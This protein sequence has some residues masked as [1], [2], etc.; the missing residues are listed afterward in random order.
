MAIS[1]N[2]NVAS[3][4]AQR[5]LVGTERK[6]N[7]A[8][9]RLSSGFRINSA[10]DDAAGLAIT[11][12]MTSQVR[13]LTQAARN[14]N[15]GISLAQTAEGA[16]NETTTLLQRMRELAIQSANDSNSDTDRQSIQDEVVNLQAEIA[17]IAD[18]TSFNNKKL[19]DGSFGNASFHIGAEA[20]Q[21]INVTTGDARANRLGSYRTRLK[22]EANVGATT[23]AATAATQWGGAD[24]VVNGSK[25]SAT[26]TIAVGATAK[27][28]ADAINAKTVD[29]G[30]TA[31]AETKVELTG[32]ADGSYKF[33]L[34]TGSSQTATVSA[35]VTSGDLNDLVDAINDHS[36]ATGVT[37]TLN[38]A[39]DG[40]VMKD[41]DGD[42]ITVQRTDTV[43]DAW[44]AT[45]SATGDTSTVATLSSAAATD[46]ASFRGQV[47]IESEKAFSVAGGASADATSTSSTLS[48]IAT[49]DLKTQT[50]SNDA[51]SVIDKAIAKV[52]SIR[53]KLGAVQNRFESTI[54]NLTNVSENISASRSRILDA[55]FAA[56][57]AELSKAQI[58][59]Q[60]GLSMLSQANQLPQSALSML[61]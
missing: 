37:A 36:A 39:E 17:R 32:I 58:I 45:M 46:T 9:Q 31:S 11:D 15:D 43:A 50:G 51:I 52:D 13:G 25:G 53:S 41:A 4:T 23:T 35:A 48:Q 14:A 20:G 8:L 56:E 47:L 6:L 49:V 29:T 42:T 22:G 7:T 1:V 60:A 28:A 33:T 38:D 24:L 18:T 3:L 40:I 27:D 2:T 12:R 10:K 34:S 19:L 26:A 30:V 44:T 54:T 59:Q 55:D 21:V 5:N 61:Q 16:L 57:T